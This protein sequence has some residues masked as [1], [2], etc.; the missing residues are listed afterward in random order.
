MRKPSKRT[1][2][3]IGGVAVV[4]ALYFAAQVWSYATAR[5][6]VYEFTQ[7][8]NRWRLTVTKHARLLPLR[9]WGLGTIIACGDTGGYTTWKYGF[10]ELEKESWNTLVSGSNKAGRTPAW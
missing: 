9:D 7:D 4:W 5:P 6:E 10:F 3:V 2:K 8:G 1:W